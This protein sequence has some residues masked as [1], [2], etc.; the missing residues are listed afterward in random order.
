MTIAKL[1][2]VE[3]Y[4]RVDGKGPLTFFLFNGAGCNTKTWGETADGLMKLGR[5]VRF[6]ARTTGQTVCPAEPYSLD[7]LAED[8]I[9]LMDY[10]DIEKAILVGHAFGGRIAQIFCRENADR[11]LAAILCGTGGFLPPIPVNSDQIE[12]KNL[13]SRT[14]REEMYLA[15]YTGKEFKSRFPERARRLLDETLWAE[16][17]RDRS[18]LEMRRKALLST[19]VE[20]YW[21]KIPHHIPVLLLYGTDD[22]FGTPGNATDLDKRLKDSRLVFI[23]GAGH[24]AIRENPERILEEIGKFL[25]D[26]G[27]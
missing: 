6:D 26:K 25:I 5:V 2:R 7:T 9:T 20:S 3:T 17:A 27:L 4:Y 13:D 18:E 22:K 21:G 12:K 15:T 10:L 23:E 11:V 16:P 19:P 8:A 1:N 14:L 24:M